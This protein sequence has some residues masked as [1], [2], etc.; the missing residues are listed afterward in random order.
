MHKYI[1]WGTVA[2]GVVTAIVIG[3]LYV[4]LVKK[5]TV[6]GEDKYALKNP[7]AK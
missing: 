1:N 7:L 2:T 4:A 3:A 6:A 5:T